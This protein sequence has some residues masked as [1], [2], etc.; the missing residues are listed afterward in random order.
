MKGNKKM[1]TIGV[2]VCFFLVGCSEEYF[3]KLEKVKTDARIFCWSGERLI[4]EGRSNGTVNVSTGSVY[5]F[6]EKD[7][8]RILRVSGHCIIDYGA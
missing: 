5:L 7:S 1:R 6:R 4:Y 2:A 8:N 3:H